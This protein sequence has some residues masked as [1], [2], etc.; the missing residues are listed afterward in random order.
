MSVLFYWAHCLLGLFLH[1]L[2]LYTLICKVGFF[3]LAHFFFF[4][5]SLIT[6]LKPA[7]VKLTGFGWGRSCPTLQGLSN[8][9]D[10]TDDIAQ[11]QLFCCMGGVEALGQVYG[12]QHKWLLSL[13]LVQ[14]CRSLQL[15]DML[16]YSADL[17]NCHRKTSGLAAHHKGRVHPTFLVGWSAYC[18]AWARERDEC[19]GQKGQHREGAILMFYQR[20][21]REQAAKSEFVPLS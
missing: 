7:F 10:V 5:F 1:Q 21:K 17:V 3:S 8:L 20:V 4:S 19:S 15:Y 2:L 11:L 6:V 9:K 12:A 13:S 18:L 16:F 14:H